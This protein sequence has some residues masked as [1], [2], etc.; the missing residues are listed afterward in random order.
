MDSSPFN[1][2]LEPAIA[3][4]DIK[5]AKEELRQAIQV[6]MNYKLNYSA[7]WAGELLV[8]ISQLSAPCPSSPQT[9]SSY[10]SL[11]LARTLFDLKE[12][13]KAASVLTE[14]NKAEYPEA[15]FLYN[16]SLFMYGEFR[17]EEESIEEGK[18]VDNKQLYSIEANLQPIDAMC[19]YLLAIV[20]KAKGEPSHAKELLTHSLNLFP[21][22]WS[23]WLELADICS[24]EDLKSVDNHWMKN[25]FIAQFYHKMQRSEEA[26]DLYAVLAEQYFPSSSFIYAQIGNEFFLM[27]D[28]T[29]AQ[30]WFE[31]V[32]EIDPYR[33]ELMDVYSNILYVRENSG[34]LSYLAYRMFHNDKYR[35][36]TC[37]VLGNYYSLKN[38]HTR[39]MVYFKRA[40]S[41]NKNYLPAW[42]LMGHEY[43][44]MQ[45]VTKA[46]E[47]YRIAIELDPKDYRAWYGLAETYEVS[48]MNLY[49]IYYYYKAIMTRPQDSRLWVALATCYEKMGKSTEATKCY[50]RAERIKDREGVV[51]HRLARLY[52]RLGLIEKACLAFKE[53]LSRKD[54]ENDTGEETVEA[55]MFLKNYHQDKDMKEEANYYAR[56]LYDFG[57]AELDSA[58]SHLR[59]T[60]A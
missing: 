49:A 2:I 19:S 58:T 52:A 24:L 34:K 38:D 1:K 16:Y 27:D 45:N 3:I 29:S 7:K 40:T 59:Q 4:D 31:Q 21:V 55:I 12:Y 56:R 41:L 33:Y 18:E 26:I 42:I 10:D 23:A 44:E 9:D 14:F 32:E 39:A 48:D 20:K 46:I 5:F 15:Y 37:F 36:E 60:E 53:S 6:L 17:K 54:A 13:I 11:Q 22:N 51:L 50:E 30:N 35:P 28:Y 8:S 25:F 57:G 43:L 47:S